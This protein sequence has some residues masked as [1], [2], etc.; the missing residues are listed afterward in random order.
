MSIN[1]DGFRPSFLSVKLIKMSLLFEKKS[2]AMI[3][4]LT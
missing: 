4:I 2:Y 1:G 3:F